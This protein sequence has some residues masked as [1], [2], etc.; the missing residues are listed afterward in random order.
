MIRR[1]V[2]RPD[3]AAVAIE[4]GATRS[5]PSPG[6]R[7]WSWIVTSVVPATDI[8]F[9]ARARVWVQRPLQPAEASSRP[10]RPNASSHRIQMEAGQPPWS[11]SMLRLGRSPPSYEPAIGEV[12]GAKIS[13][14]FCHLRR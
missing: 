14:A 5:T 1:T 6:R 8:Q 2:R 9:S 3:R 4:H 7:S 12:S 10:G 11:S 13:S